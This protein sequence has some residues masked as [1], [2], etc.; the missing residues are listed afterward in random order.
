MIQYEEIRQKKFSADFQKTSTA[1]DRS[2]L[3]FFLKN[4]TN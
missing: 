1:S 2:E 3:C 4:K